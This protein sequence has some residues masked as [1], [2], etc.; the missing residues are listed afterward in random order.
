MS[1]TTLSAIPPNVKQILQMYGAYASGVVEAHYQPLYSMLAYPSAGQANFS[2][3]TTGSTPATLNTTN[4]P[5][6]GGQLPSPIN[7]LILGVEVIFKSGLTP[8]SIVTTSGE[9]AAD[10]YYAAI[11]NDVGYFELKIGTKPYL[12]VAPLSALG[13]SDSPTYNVALS[14]ATTASATTINNVA[15]NFVPARQSAGI[16]PL[17]LKSNESFYVTITYPGGKVALPSGKAGVIGVRL[18]GYQYQNA[19]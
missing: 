1:N 11:D 8:G 14:A 2:F 4:L 6:N 18:N 17:L 3:F 7:Y 9:T 5:G 16:T 12:Q 13:E 15:G 19:Q 10:D